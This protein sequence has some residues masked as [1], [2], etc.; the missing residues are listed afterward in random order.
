VHDASY[1]VDDGSFRT[2]AASDGLFDEP[3]EVISFPITGLRAGTHRVVVRVHDSFGNL[4]TAAI[5][6]RVK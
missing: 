4:D 5:I 6:V 1:R 3:D 2:V